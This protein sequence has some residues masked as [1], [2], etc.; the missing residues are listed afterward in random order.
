M[1]TI[2]P[3]KRISFMRVLP[4]TWRQKPADIEITSLSPMYKSVQLPTSADKVTLLAFAAARRTVA[5][6]VLWRAPLSIDISCPPGP[7][8]QTCRTLLQRSIDG[9]YRRDGWRR[10]YL[11]EGTRFSL[12]Q[13]RI[14]PKK[15]PWKNTLHIPSIRFDRTPDLWQTDTGR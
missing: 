15:H 7:Q 10:T 9:T 5:S 14:G 12:K 1:I 4:T 2:L 8:Q 3:T 13:C 6:T 11:Y